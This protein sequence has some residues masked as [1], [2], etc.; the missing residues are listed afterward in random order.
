MRR[1]MTTI[2][3]ALLGTA[4][5]GGSARADE[6]DKYKLESASTQLSTTQAGAHPDF[7]VNFTLSEAAGEPYALTRDIEVRL[8]AGLFGNPQPFPTCTTA[9][10]GTE[11]K[12]SSCPLDSQVGSTQVTVGGTSAGTFG[13]PIYNMTSPGGNVVARFGFFAAAYPATI[14]VRLNPDDYSLSAVVEGAPAAAS[15]IAASSTFW[16]VPASP[17]HD[18]E[19]VTPAE[20]I[21]DNGP[22]GGRRSTLPEV[23]FMTNPTSC[24]SGRQVR[25]TVT[26][27]QR[28]ENP[29]TITTGFPQITGCGL[30]SFDPTVTAGATSAAASSPTGLD[31]GLDFSTRGL[32]HPNLLYESEPN[33]AEVLLPEGM[34]INPS[35][36]EGLGVCSEAELVRETF[37][38]GPNEGCPESSKVGTATAVSPAL[39]KTAEGSLFVAQPY[40]N[41]FGSLIALYLVL[42][43]PNRGVLVKLAGQVNPN[44]LTGRLTTVFDEIP[45]LPVSSFD[46]NFREGPR[47]PLVTPATCGTY[48]F[49]SHF[50]PWAAPLTD[51]IRESPFAITFGLGG[52]ACP[53]GGAPLHPGLVAG[54]INNAAAAYSPFYV[55]I[56]RNDAEQEITHFSIKLPPGVTGKLAGIP[57]CSDQA[58]AAAMAREHRPDGAGEE[59]EHPSCPAVSEVGHMLVG[60]GVGSSLTYVPGK[61]YLA[62]PY[63]GDPL[64]VVAIT[65]A[66]AGPFDLGTVVVREGLAVDPETA[67][68]FVDA[69]GSTAIPH[70]LDG[71]PVRLRDVRIYVD[72]RDFV[73]NPTS[74]RPSSTAATVIGSG[75]DFVSEADDRPVTVTT[76]F[77]A[78]DCASLPFK[79]KLKLSLV[80]QTKRTGNPAVKAVL[81]Q[82]PGHNANIAG[83]TVILP[84]GEFIDNAHVDSPCT[85]VQFNSGHVAGE[86]CP[87]KSILGT[88]KATT[89]LLDKPLEGPV[90]FRSNGGERE[91]PDLV[92]V[93]RGQIEIRL[94]G[95]I[96]SVGR[97]HAEVRRV[98]TRFLTLPDAPVSRFE[99][100]LAGGKKGLLENSRNLCKGKHAATLKLAGHNGKV[101]K[102]NSAVLTSCKKFG[103]KN[104]SKGD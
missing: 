85:R 104:R 81:T 40:R 54:S 45:Q 29:S 37:D 8:P 92:V 50:N 35:Q 17:S 58:I 94:V 95:F 24:E 65:T 66:K 39:D 80:G 79:P 15:L 101:E 64:S 96:D 53:S 100:N 12:N 18:I 43:V 68:V 99:L 55:D 59:L 51:V 88:A 82:P 93:L 60:A 5:F 84:P 87:R 70:I 83:S 11:A 16:G 44:P 41:P 32:E 89:P 73:R 61:V 34:T 6:F 98:R 74:C 1:L 27:Y 63:Q 7:T 9:Q 97:K 78:A 49:A 26:S 38:S 14:V 23:P 21:A 67:E 75:T 76:R 72:R 3:V 10:L 90:Y 20:A 62:G 86:N 77:Q 52:G 4:L 19:R 71:I 30:L 69:A 47:A 42:K 46:L 103:A 48:S 28:P 13:E 25:I 91:L 22:P 36:A 2:A 57:Y 102:L 56:S 33:R 31:Y